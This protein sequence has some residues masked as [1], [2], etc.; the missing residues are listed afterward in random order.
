[1]R[2]FVNSLDGG[3]TSVILFGRPG[4]FF[5]E[6]AVIDGL[7]RSA[8]AVALDSTTLFILPRD[9]FRE[10]MRLSPR[11][12]LNFMQLLSRRVRYSTRQMDSVVSLP[13]R[14]RLASKLMELAQDYGRPDPLGVCIPLSLTQSN[15]ASLIGATRESTNKCLREFRQSD[16]LRFR[17][18]QIIIID[19][20][21]LRACSSS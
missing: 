6:L 15:L 2:I 7:P 18:G 20:D 10:K 4:D 12:A 11:L 21:A 17:A 13:V 19:P 8:T 5:G 16:W 3:E 14:Q 9:Q 1:M